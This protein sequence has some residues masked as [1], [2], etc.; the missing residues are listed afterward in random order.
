MITKK[1]AIKIGQQ[2]VNP[3]LEAKTEKDDVL[4][5]TIRGTVITILD[6]VWYNLFDGKTKEYFGYNKDTFYKESGWE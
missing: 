4:R 1:D 6:N 3:A 5:H 2:I